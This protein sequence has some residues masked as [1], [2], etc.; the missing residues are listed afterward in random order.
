MADS[1]VR[2]A[3]YLRRFYGVVEERPTHY[4]LVLNSDTL[5]FELMSDLVVRA[6]ALLSASLVPV[7]PPA[8]WLQ[9]EVFF[10]VVACR[11]GWSLEGSKA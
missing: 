2:R 8:G 11:G 6:A 4:D 7:P 1:D 3:Q 9:C 5:S 10:S